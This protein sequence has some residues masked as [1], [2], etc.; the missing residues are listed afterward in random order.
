MT[1]INLPLHNQ[2][3]A[4]AGGGFAAVLVLPGALLPATNEVLNRRVR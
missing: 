2:G 4:P 3:S 1:S